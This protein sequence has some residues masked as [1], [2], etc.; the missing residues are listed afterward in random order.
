LI[1][2]PRTF[3]KGMVLPPIFDRQA[4]MLSVRFHYHN[5]V[6]SHNRIVIHQLFS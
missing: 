2:T 5:R 3:A 4:G 1:L 6:G